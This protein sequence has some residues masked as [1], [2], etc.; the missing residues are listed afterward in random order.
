V[1]GTFKKFKMTSG[2]KSSK[3]EKRAVNQAN[4]RPGEESNEEVNG[5][6]KGKEEVSPVVSVQD[7]FFVIVV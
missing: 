5:T 4:T 2:G 3:R 1:V 7:V 6:R